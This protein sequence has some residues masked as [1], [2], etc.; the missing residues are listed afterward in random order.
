MTHPRR[1]RGIPAQREREVP[2]G[3]H[4]PP[5]GGAAVPAGL[6]L[7]QPGHQ[8]G[9]PGRPAGVRGLRGLA[10][11][12]LPALGELPLDPPARSG[13]ARSR[14]SSGTIW[15][16][17]AHR[18][19]LPADRHP[20]GDLPGGVRRHH[21]LV[22][23]ADR[24]QHRRTSPA[25]PSIVY[26]ILGLGIIARGFGLGTTV[27]TAAITLS[28]LVLPVV[29]IASREAI[30][31]V[32]Q[33]DPA[34]LARARR[35]QVADHLATGP[36]GRDPRHRDRLDPR[37]VAGHRRGRAA[38]AARRGDLRRVQPGRPDQCVHRA[39]DPDLRLDQ[40]VP[41]GVPGARR[42]RDRHPAGRSCC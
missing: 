40:A 7:C 5:A 38:A 29:I 6:L 18:A 13:P 37:A 3:P 9:L 4:A 33:L 10:A 41:R 22:E 30:R 2:A 25:V 35:H 42:G 23:P 32:P 26:G 34:R 12:G 15:V 21:P 20:R 1:R 14:R 27:L 11:A 31:A 19:D 17:G 39:A 24:A 36:A 8:R 28:L 16:I